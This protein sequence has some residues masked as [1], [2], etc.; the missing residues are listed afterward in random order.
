MSE[1]FV[2]RGRIGKRSGLQGGALEGTVKRCG[3]PGG[4]LEGTVKRE[5]G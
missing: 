3:L 4:A 2:T 1:G 5:L